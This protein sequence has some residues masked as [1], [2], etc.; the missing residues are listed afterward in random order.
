ME[1]QYH[2]YWPI[3]S[4]LT[5]AI[6]SLSPTVPDCFSNNINKYRSAINSI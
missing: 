2:L 4:Y 6:Q 3:M 1:V 5:T